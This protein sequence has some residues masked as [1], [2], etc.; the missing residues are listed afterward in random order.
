[1]SERVE[2]QKKAKGERPQYFADPAIDKILSITMALAGEMAVMRD[3]LDTVECLLDK[4][5]P[6]TREAIDGYRPDPDVRAERDA[7]REVYLSNVLRIV[8]Q[9]REDLEKNAEGSPAY[10]DAIQLV[11]S[12]DA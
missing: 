6:V 8:H 9:E 10:D 11:E 12:E 1:M 2:L 4:G 5:E 3:R 7:W